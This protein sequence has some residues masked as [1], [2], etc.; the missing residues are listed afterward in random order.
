MQSLNAKELKKTYEIYSRRWRRSLHTQIFR[1]HII[2]MRGTFAERWA[3]SFTQIKR[4][5]SN[6][7]ATTPSRPGLFSPRPRPG[8]AGTGTRASR[9]STTPVFSWPARVGIVSGKWH[10]TGLVSAG[11][12]RNLGVRFIIVGGRVAGRTG[13][14]VYR[15]RCEPVGGSA[16]IRHGAVMPWAVPRVRAD[17]QTL[18]G[19]GKTAHFESLS[20]FDEWG[21]LSF[22]DWGFALVHEVHNALDFPAA[23][24]L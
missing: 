4:S 14:V 18:I 10:G 17:R 11:Q 6:G 12:V 2:Q 1:G 19:T 8:R 5:V 22:R 23:N 13:A 24:I 15:A 7:V 21:E 16:A 3:I 20:G 9:T